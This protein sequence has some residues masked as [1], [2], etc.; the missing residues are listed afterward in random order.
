MIAQYDGLYELWPLKYA[1]VCSGILTRKKA[2][3][4]INPFMHDVLK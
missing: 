1:V 4:L 3:P 2:K